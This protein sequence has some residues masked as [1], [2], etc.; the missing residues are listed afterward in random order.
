MSHM[1][2]LIMDQEEDMKNANCRRHYTGGR[3][4]S[5]NCWECQAEYRDDDVSESEN[6][7]DD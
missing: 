2:R 7:N 4:L 5:I 1:K 6:D 3:A